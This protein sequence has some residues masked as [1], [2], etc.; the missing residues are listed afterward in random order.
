MFRGEWIKR[1]QS[2]KDDPAASQMGDFD[3]QQFQD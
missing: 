1:G 2:K 3:N